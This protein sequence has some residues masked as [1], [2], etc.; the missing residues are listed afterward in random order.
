MA[1][2]ELFRITQELSQ[3]L[4]TDVGTDGGRWHDLIEA[5]AEL[6]K[7]EFEA[8]VERLRRLDLL[9][10]SPADRLNIWD[11]LRRMI[12][13]HLEFPNAAWA[14]PR[15]QVQYLEEVYMRFEPDDLVVQRSWLFVDR[16]LLPR[17]GSTDWRERQQAIEQARV[18]AVQELFALGGL[19]LVL[20]LARQAKSP[21]HVGIALGQSD[22]L[23]DQEGENRLLSG[24]LGAADTVLREVGFG[25]LRGRVAVRGRGWLQAVRRRKVVQTWTSQQRADLYQYLPFSTRTWKA[26]EATDDET[27]RLYWEDVSI[28]GRGDIP[29]K[30]CERAIRKFVE[31]GRLDAAVELLALYSGRGNRRFQPQLIADVLVQMVQESITQTIA[32]ELLADDIAELLDILQQSAETGSARLAQ[33]E[34][35]FLPLLDRFE[36]EPKTLHRA[37]AED[38]DFFVE[39]LSWAYK[40]EEEEPRELS[41]AQRVR[42]RLAADLLHSWRRPPGL[43]RDGAVNPEQLRAWVARARELAVARGRGKIGDQYIGQVLINYPEGAD[44]AWPHEAVREFIEE[45][46][47]EHLERGISIGIFNSRGMVQRAIGEGG[48]QERTIVERYAGYARLLRDGWPRTAR[49]IRAI[50]NSYEA[51]ARGEDTQAELEEDLWR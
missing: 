30:D 24:V 22:I 41:E 49:L 19:T 15:E 32:W 29:V 28:V 51:E 31:Y 50:A 6:P 47:S 43:G 35:F 23:A 40:A 33:L 14:L 12:S 42:G 44:G 34:W 18:Q 16:P 20:D 38:P 9:A 21:W 48:A 13:K 1:Y 27:Q 37:L 3:R 10:F 36:R 26:L 25:F 17:R 7:D 8:I 39:V 11:T 4:I 2:G 5:L 45:V 46:A